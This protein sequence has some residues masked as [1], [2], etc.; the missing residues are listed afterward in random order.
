MYFILQIIHEVDKI[1]CVFLFAFVIF[2]N[3][4]NHLNIILDK[5]LNLDTLLIQLNPIMHQFKV[6]GQVVGISSDLLDQIESSTANPHDGLVEVCDAWLRKCRDNDVTLT[7]KHV[8]EALSLIGQK[9]LSHD[10]M[11]VYTT[12]KVL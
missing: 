8:A 9:Q 2:Y 4:V 12:G 6:L 1:D 5:E 10:I 11:Q 3:C 7:W